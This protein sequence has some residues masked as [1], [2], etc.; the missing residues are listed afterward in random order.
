MTITHFR[1]TKTFRVLDG[2]ATVIGF[3][4]PRLLIRQILRY[5]SYLENH[6]LNLLLQLIICVS[7]LINAR[8][9]YIVVHQ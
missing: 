5:S 3:G 4:Y 8:L 1:H 7:F 9:K 6:V 2:A